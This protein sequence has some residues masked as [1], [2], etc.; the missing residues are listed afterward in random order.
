MPYWIEYAAWIIEQVV[1]D[2]YGLFIVTFLMTLGLQ[3]WR[4]RAEYRRYRVAWAALFI[5]GTVWGGLALWQYF[6]RFNVWYEAYF[7]LPGILAAV[8]LAKLQQWISSRAFLSIVATIAVVSLLA[9]AVMQ[10][11]RK[12]DVSNRADN[13]WNRPSLASQI[14]SRATGPAK[15][16]LG[17][18]GLPGGAIGWMSGNTPPFDWFIYR[19]FG[20]VVLASTIAV[21]PRRVTAIA[22]ES[23][24]ARGDNAAAATIT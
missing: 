17:H 5:V 22:K 13:P 2:Y 9:I 11:Y 16:D 14:H 12:D 24:T 18:G 3:A 23:G 8:L 15:R 19:S 1:G 21:P 20:L 6:P 4:R 7:L 10:P